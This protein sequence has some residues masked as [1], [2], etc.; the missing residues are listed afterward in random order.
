MRFSERGCVLTK[1]G[2][3]RQK[4][5]DDID[6]RSKESRQGGYNGLKQKSGN[7]GARKRMSNMSR[8]KGRMIAIASSKQNSPSQKTCWWNERVQGGQRHVLEAHPPSYKSS[9]Q[10]PSGVASGPANVQGVESR[11]QEA[12][13]GGVAVIGSS[14]E[15][16][17]HWPKPQNTKVLECI[18]DMGLL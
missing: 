7:P 18:S 8:M 13:V 16:T 17:G 11:S 12:L 1:R 6:S 3:P 15:C 14:P 10:S 9:P 5:A 2:G 4:L